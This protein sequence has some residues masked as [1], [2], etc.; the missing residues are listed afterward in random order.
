MPAIDNTEIGTLSRRRRR[1]LRSKTSD[2]LFRFLSICSSL[3][4]DKDG[5]N[6]GSTTND[7]I[8]SD[9]TNI[10]PND[11]SIQEEISMQ[12]TRTVLDIQE[13]GVFNKRA[14]SAEHD[15]NI[16]GEKEDL[17]HKIDTDRSSSF[18]IINQDNHDMTNLSPHLYADK[19]TEEGE[20]SGE[21]M[22]LMHEDD[23]QSVE[24]TVIGVENLIGIEPVVKNVND[25]MPL[26]TDTIEDVDK[27]KEG[28]VNKRS[29]SV[30]DYSEIAVHP[31]KDVNAQN[32]RKSQRR[33]NKKAK[34][35]VDLDDISEEVIEASANKDASTEKKRKRTLSEERKAKKK[36]NDR[37][38][39]A[40]KNKKLGVKRLKLEPMIREKKVTYCRHYLKGRCHEGDKCKYSHDTV[41]ETKSKPCCHFAR[42]ACMKGDDCPYDHQLSKY[43]CNNHF[44]Q[45]FCTRGSDCM[46]SHHQAQPTESILNPSNEM[47]PEQQKPPSSP[48]IK[49][50]DTKS[51]S[52]PT[53]VAS[54]T[55]SNITKSTP[56]LP[57]R[58]PKGISFLSREKL[59]LPSPTVNG[60][61]VK[62][63][64]KTPP[65]ILNS[66]EITKT[67]PAVPRGINFL[68]FG[69]KPG[70]DHSNI[71]N[72]IK[73]NNAT[74]KS[75][76]SNLTDSGS[77]SKSESVL[78]TL[79]VDIATDKPNYS[80]KTVP[81]LSFMS[82]ASQKALRSTLDF[83]LKFESGVKT[84]RPL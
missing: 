79:K 55:Q 48:G 1:P 51:C 46:F 42:N 76:L 50:I 6:V 52:P 25:L 69:K 44:T 23:T 22:D 82:S 78:D 18:D 8:P 45:G 49:T 64:T 24:N 65:V 54:N 5:N 61:E 28:V 13:E 27:D 4:S 67:P 17:S 68:S 66:K 35:H 15:L 34:K 12:N 31:A 53:F 37:I 7:H 62:E 47:K 57:V 36:R 81:T 80:I 74:G 70:L 2:E 73:T 26:L 30:V 60:V 16:S 72:F 38:K 19:G 41:P 83:A 14:E 20:I 59:P 9:C 43:P 32:T 11:T 21:F 10:T 84:K 56:S 58:P 29:R 75:H 3:F 71:G 40:E 39:R 33:R 63:I 77:G